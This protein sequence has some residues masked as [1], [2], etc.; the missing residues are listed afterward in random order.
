M[1]GFL[2]KKNFCDGWDN[3]FTLVL[4]NLIY[5]FSAGAV[6]VGFSMLIL[7][8]PLGAEGNEAVAYSIA[9]L[10]IF[11]FYFVYCLCSF[12]FGDLAHQI[13]DFNSVRVVDFFKAIPSCLK[14]AA[15]YAL[16]TAALTVISLIGL[17]WYFVQ[18]TYIYF[19][20]GCVFL[21]FDFFA[22]LALQWFIPV[23]AIMHNNFRKCLKKC[24]ILVLDNTA[25]TIGLT[26]YSFVLVIFSLFFLGFAPSIAGITLARVNALRLRLYK[27]DYLELHPE[28]KTRRERKQIPWEELIYEDRET[29]GPRKL[30][31]FLFPWKE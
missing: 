3:L 25:F 6:A 23:R 5:M 31:S 19:L 27:Y 14:D 21:W 4:V 2:I 16:M 26:L 1:F 29:L 8:T 12:A 18:G 11:L 9:A 13:A 28:L 7:K 10:G 17:R 30:R 15:L 24:L 22:I 20:L